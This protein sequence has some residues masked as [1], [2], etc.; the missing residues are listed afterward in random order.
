MEKTKKNR[1]KKVILAA[2]AVAAVACI[3][4]SMTLAYLTGSASKTNIFKGSPNVDAVLFEPYW[5]GSSKE[6][7]G[8]ED[9][10]VLKQ[11]VDGTSNEPYGKTEAE[12]YL[13]DGSASSRILKNPKMANTS[14]NNDGYVAMKLT[15]K[16]KL[17]ADGD[18][19]NVTK[20][21]F[22]NLVSI[23]YTSNI[24]TEEIQTG[25]LGINKTNWTL[26]SSETG[27]EKSAV[28]VYNT[29]L[30]KG[31][32]T[33]ELFSY[34]KVNESIIPAQ[35][36]C[37]TDGKPVDSSSKAEDG[38]RIINLNSTTYTMPEFKIEISGAIV[39]AD[40]Y[41]SVD[42]TPENAKIALSKLLG[43]ENLN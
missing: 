6:N 33:E 3:T 8:A 4:S 25:D 34:I 37:L 39:D 28:Y 29:K 27:K 2:L 30:A 5:D 9:T 32:E 23:Y 7:D 19:T 18:Y 21:E 14:Q 26:L 16:V 20:E 38:Y 12:H 13:N 11:T 40:S 42:E 41:Q 36:F 43:A 15:Y 31:T 35:D 22:E 1:I 10:S 17:T 24:G